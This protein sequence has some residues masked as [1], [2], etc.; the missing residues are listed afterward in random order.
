MDKHDNIRDDCPSV[1]HDLLRVDVN[2][3]IK[4]IVAC[5]VT[6]YPCTKPENFGVLFDMC[7]AIVNS[8]EWSILIW[9]DLSLIWLDLTWSDLIWLDLDWSGLIWL[10]L[11][12]IWRMIWEKIG[13]IV[14]P[15]TTF[16]KFYCKYWCFFQV[17]NSNQ[18]SIN[19]SHF[20]S[21]SD[22]WSKPLFVSTI[23]VWSEPVYIIISFCTNHD[24]LLAS[25]VLRNSFF[26]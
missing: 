18:Q 10:D 9:F 3:L 1:L 23:N 25:F 15:N 22:Q 8:S 26:L 24:L 20:R 12:L 17:S 16:M 21:N 4:N 2:L 11:V 14:V 13:L 6:Q 5:I 7:I 19:I